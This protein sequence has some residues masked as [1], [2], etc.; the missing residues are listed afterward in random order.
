MFS[1]KLDGCIKPLVVPSA[2]GTED[3]AMAYTADK[4]PPTE[5]SEQLRART[6]GWGADLDPVDRASVPRGRPEPTSRNV[7]P[8]GAV[9]GLD[10]PCL[11]ASGVRH[12]LVPVPLG[13]RPHHRPDLS[14]Q[15]D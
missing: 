8:H 9:R 13:G 3:A 14:A 4:P 1:A 6:P 2:A 7:R 15:Y 10:R 11:T 5:S 12:H